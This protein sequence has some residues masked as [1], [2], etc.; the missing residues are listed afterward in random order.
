VFFVFGYL[1]LADRRFEQAVQKNGMFALFVGITSFLIIVATMYGPAFM[2]FWQVTPGYS[3][4]YA[5]YQLLFSITAWSLMIF[6]LYF[7]KRFLN[8]DGS[9]ARGL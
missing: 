8:F 9:H 2:N 7:A 6:V 4:I 5:L 1:F 3:L